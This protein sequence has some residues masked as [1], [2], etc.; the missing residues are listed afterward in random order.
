MPKLKFKIIRKNSNKA[1]LMLLKELNKTKVFLHCFHSTTTSIPLSKATSNLKKILSG[2]WCILVYYMKT[3]LPLRIWIKSKQ[4]LKSV[5]CI[6]EFHMGLLLFNIQI[7]RRNGVHSAVQVC[8]TMEYFTI[9]RFLVLME[10][11]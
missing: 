9:H 8:L 5:L 1:R 7:L 2:K 10:M 4:L 11:E 6:R 3:K